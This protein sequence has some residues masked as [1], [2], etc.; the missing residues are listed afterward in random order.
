MLCR[1]YVNIRSGFPAG[2]VVKNPQANAGDT[3]L[4]SGL[5][6]SPGEGKG[7]LC[8]YFGLGNPTDR[9]AWWAVTVHGVE[10]GQTQLSDY[11]C[12]HNSRIPAMFK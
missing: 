5:G 8:Q 11:A 12:T 7:K 6:R 10:K 4:I 2:A 3:G 9:G 1:W